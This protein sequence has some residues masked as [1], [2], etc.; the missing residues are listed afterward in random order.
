MF[1]KNNLTAQHAFRNGYFTAAGLTQM[2]DDWVQSIEQVKK[3]D[4][5]VAQFTVP[6]DVGDE[7]LLL[8]KTYNGM[9]LMTLHYIG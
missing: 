2:T 7:D 1:Y 5:A 6:L 4:A 8:K 9:V 3:P